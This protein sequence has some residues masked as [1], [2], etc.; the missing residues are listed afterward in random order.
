[1]AC[2]THE[3]IGQRERIS[4]DLVTDIVG[5]FSDLKQLPKSSVTSA[6]HA[7]EDFAVPL[8]NV[9]KQQEKSPGS[10]H[11]GNSELRWVD[12]LLYLYTEPFDIVVDPFAGGRRA[13][14]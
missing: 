4:R 9:W 3:E 11:F 7:D 1:M 14:K 8:Y 2:Y 13:E 5:E 6:G 12:N 10:E